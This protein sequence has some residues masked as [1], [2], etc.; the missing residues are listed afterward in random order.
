MANTVTTR[1]S[2]WATAKTWSAS[3]GLTAALMNLEV[4]DKVNAIKSPAYFNC[5][6]DNATD[7]SITGTTTFTNI[8]GTASG[9]YATVTTG[10]G[11]MLIGFA[12]ALTTGGGLASYRTYF[13]VAVDGTRIGLNDGLLTPGYQ[14][15]AANTSFVVMTEVLSA[16][17]H[18]FALQWKVSNAA[19]TATLYAGAGTANHDL[20]P[21][22][23]GIELV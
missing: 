19:A 3:E 21:R 13:D 8:D 1:S 10:G 18:T 6:I 23:W 22:F 14:A 4:R 12:G 5:V 11:A 9:L 17:S 16:G 7:Y 20:H 2:T 15:N